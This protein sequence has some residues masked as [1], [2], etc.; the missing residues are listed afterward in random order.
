MKIALVQ[1]PV[2]GTYDPPIALAQLSSC[3]KKAG[4]DVTAFDLNIKLYIARAENYKNMWAWEQCLFWYNND[5]VNKFFADNKAFIDKCV[6]EILGLKPKIIGFS[7]NASSK[8]SSL[9][10]ARM[11]K[12]INKDIIIIFGG[13]LF[14]EKKFIK[15]ILE[16]DTIDIVVPGEGELTFVELVEFIESNKDMETCLGVAFK[17]AGRIIST[18]ERK[19]IKNLDVL[20]FLDFTDLPLSN[21]DDSKHLV[22]MASRGCVQRCAFCSSRAFWP[23][24]RTMSGKRIFEEI[25]SIKIQQG[26]LNSNLGHIDFIDLMFNGNMKYLVEFCDLMTKANL[27]ITW[28]AN[29]IIR[30]EMTLSVIKKIK[31]SGCEHI[32]FGIESGSQRVLNLMHKNYKIKDADRIIKY[33]HEAGIVVTGN[34]MFGFP[35]E[36]E[37]DFKET[38][39][40]IERNAKFL[41]RVYPSRTYCAIEE[42]SYL[43]DHPE[44]F[45]IKPNPP[46]HLFWESVDG[47]NTYPMRLDRCRRFS[48][49]AFS[50][51]IEVGCGVQTS[52]QLDE[53]FNLY[54][55]YEVKKDYNKTLEHLLKYFE[56]EPSNEV[57]VNKLKDY[58]IKINEDQSVITDTELT[59]KLI[60]TMYLI[61][62]EPET[63]PKERLAGWVIG[64]ERSLSLLKAVQN[65]NLNLNDEEFKN[66]KLQLKSS[67]KKI[68]FCVSGLHDSDNNDGK[69]FNL[70]AYKAHFEEKMSAE[71]TKV[72]E[73]IFDNKIDFFSLSDSEQVFDYFDEYFPHVV[74]VFYTNGSSL[75]SWVFEKVANSKSVHILNFILPASNKTLYNVITNKNNFNQIIKNTERLIGSKKY[76]GKLWLNFVFAATALNIENLPNFVRLAADLK[77]DKVICYYKFIYE[78]SQ[79][80]VS[81]FFKQDLTNKMLEEA[82]TL[83]NKLNIKIDLPPRFGL[84]KYHDPGI[85]REPFSQIMF[86]AQGHVLPC[87][88]SE[89]CN[90]ILSNDKNFI[91]LWNSDYYKNLRKSLIEGTCSCFKHCLRA[92]P[93]SINDFES[94]VIHRGGNKNE[95]INILW[96]DNLKI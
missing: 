14:F 72:E 59:Y 63:E 60:M 37:E 23:G 50:S 58:F 67:P 44:E 90:E 18:G 16:E 20:P 49:K 74:K 34:F 7:V 39:D 61:K 28:S 5:H 11:I 42:F 81:C 77:V 3:L 76:K 88:A 35:G 78:I 13:P 9:K 25:K 19:P 80:H 86:D 87:D 47:A 51:G 94:H 32:I 38:L 69:G 53:L 17:K 73:I 10:I 84:K 64:R 82:E 21:Y 27:D 96:G 75:D 79:K 15:E 93:A 26:R 33:M 95:E 70:P 36:R 85:C 8:L 83:A 31:D 45:G 65:K 4:H 54:Q 29:M 22:F 6:N 91:D 43:A 62:L 2:W 92:N 30:P 56:I 71:L 89:D 24:Y 41:D 66:S 46:N 48:E 57:V 68:S 55:Y 40:F 1:C 12:D 52:V